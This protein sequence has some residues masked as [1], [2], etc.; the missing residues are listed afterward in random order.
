MVK[1]KK[2]RRSFPFIKLYQYGICQIVIDVV[3]AV[4]DGNDATASAA[5]DDGYRFSAEATERK[6]EGLE[7]LVIRIYVYDDIFFSLFCRT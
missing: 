5:L 1:K 3:S 7:I 4:L 2:I 6:Q